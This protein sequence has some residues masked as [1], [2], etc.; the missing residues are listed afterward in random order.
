MTKISRRQFNEK[1]A[2]GA[3]ALVAASSFKSLRAEEHPRP[4]IVF[5]LADDM[6]WN[7][8][9]CMGDPVIQTPHLDAMAREGQLFD[10][11]RVTTSICCS[12]RA[13]ILSG[14]YVCTHGIDDFAK[15]F[16]EASFAHCYPAL[17][18]KHGYYTGFVGKY[19]VGTDLPEEVFDFWRGFGG[20]GQYETT[21]DQG[22]FKHLNR[23]TAE[24]CIAFLDEC[25]DNQPFCLSVSFKAPHCQDGDERQFIYEK[26]Y[27][28]L[29]ADQTMPVP[30]GNDIA[31]EEHFPEFFTRNNEARTRWHLRFATAEMQQESIRK[32]YRLITGMDRVVGDIRN[33]VNAL[34]KGNNTVFI[35]LSDNGFFLGDYGLA[36]KWY[37]YEASIR[38]PL[39]IYDP[40]LSSARRGLRHDSMAL[41]LDMAPTLLDLAGI[42]IPPS[43][44]GKS[45]MP[46]LY[47][48]GALDREE[49]FYEHNF[50]HPTIPKSEGV[51]SRAWK[52]LCYHEAQPVHE[53]LFD[54]RN[55]PHELHN[56]AAHETYAS[57]LSTMRHRYETLK[58]ECCR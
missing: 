19:G 14:Q 27:E 45:L 37:G 30:P 22:A 42:P 4:N 21:D 35:F 48:R 54:L 58:K 44:Q 47:G 3:G 16:D 1:L 55:D 9:G 56:L 12:S 32:Y 43:M 49:F 10:H 34:G 5:L 52:Y 18:G 23:V 57:Q 20:Q 33:K 46:T 17:M 41:N 50:N 24:D 25:P 29:Y 39:I 8:L 36:G 13:S 38:V 28:M 51:V 15:T 40:R 7:S 11:C 31:Y 6:R 53:E 2:R 26:E